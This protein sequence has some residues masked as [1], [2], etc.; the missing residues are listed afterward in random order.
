MVT[1]SIKTLKINNINNNKIE[2]GSWDSMEVYIWSM[3][4]V[5]RKGEVYQLPRGDELRS[6]ALNADMAFLIRVLSDFSLHLVS[7]FSWNNLC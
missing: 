7:S 4:G 5:V 6:E 1:K 3:N 2:A